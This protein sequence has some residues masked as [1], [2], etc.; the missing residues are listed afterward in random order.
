MKRIFFCLLCGTGLLQQASGQAK[1]AK[2]NGIITISFGKQNRI[3]YYLQQGT[4]SVELEGRAAITHASAAAGSDG[5]QWSSRSAQTHTYTQTAVTN[6]A[7]KATL[8]TFTHGTGTEQMQQLFYVYPGKNYFITELRVKGMACNYLSPLAAAQMSVGVKGDNRAL[9]VPFDNDMWLRYDAQPLAKAAFTGSE[10]SALYNNDTYAGVVL[11][12]LEQHVWKT[13]V[14]VAG[15]NDP[16]VTRLEVYA[17]YTDS[18]Y[19]HDLR[20]KHGKVLPQ[21]GYCRSPKI[22]VGSFADW[23]DGMETYARLSMQFQPRHIFSWTK[24]TPMGWNSWGALQDKI[25]VDKAIAVTHFFADSLQQFRNADNTLFMDLD[26]Y[27]DNLVEGGLD[28]NVSRLKQFADDCKAKGFTPGIYWAPFVDWG[29]H[30]RTMEGSTHNYKEAWT[31][32]QGKVVETDGA[33]ALDPTHPGTRDRIRHVLGKMKSLGYEMIKIDFLTHGAIESDHFYD[34]AVT[35]GMQAYAKG[36]ELI[37][38]V[39]DGT[40]LVYAAISPNLATARYVHMRRIACDAFSAIDNSEYTLNS[41]GYGWWQGHMYNYMDA[42][43][44]VFATAPDNMNRARLASSLVTGT[45]TTGDDYGTHG[46]WSGI[47]RQLLQNPALL[48]IA[49]EGKTFRPVDANT[50]NKGVNV[51]TQVIG[52]KRYVAVFNYTGNNEN[53]VVPF[54]RAGIKAADQKATELFSGNTV[55]LQGNALRV[56]VAASDAVIYRIDKL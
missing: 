42:D 48:A 16:A 27:W 30:N 47:A 28:G 37:D 36:M 50:G 33:W 11:G 39:L 49:R 3:K 18:L 35:T 21:D 34:P 2:S 19:T 15:S 7:G 53:Y 8:Y 10:V 17:G 20:N 54:N 38:S 51:F 12:S 41:T 23:R 46:K 1:Q 25:T 31:L 14:R 45:V 22:M 29:K 44:V 9:K 32:Q 43:H 13:G 56:T 24:A 55:T 6:A 52:G 5:R 26:S 40:M 4:Y